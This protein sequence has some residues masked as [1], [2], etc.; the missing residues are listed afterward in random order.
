MRVIVRKEDF[1]MT[2]E[3][4]LEIDITDRY[5]TIFYYNDKGED[6]SST[7]TNTDILISVRE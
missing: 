3:Q 7:F 4:C 6:C 2:Y 5:T 1:V